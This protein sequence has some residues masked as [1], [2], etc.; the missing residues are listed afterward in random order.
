MILSFLYRVPSTFL[1]TGP[2]PCLP[3]PH[4]RA[5]LPAAPAL[6]RYRSFLR[7]RRSLPARPHMQPPW[8]VLPILLAM[9]PALT[10]APATDVGSLPATLV[11]KLAMR[12]VFDLLVSCPLHSRAPSSQSP[13][14]PSAVAA[15]RPRNADWRVSNLPLHTS[16][17]P[18]AAA[19]WWPPPCLPRASAMAVNAKGRRNRACLAHL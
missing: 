14:P 9:W 3:L 12:P 19:P 15:S 7:H 8:P 4:R 10:D 18:C 13:L 1:E 17:P 16:S 5:S 11:G 6:L 2:P